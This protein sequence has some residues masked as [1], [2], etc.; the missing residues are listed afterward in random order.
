MEDEDGALLEGEPPEGSL[1]LVAVV[2]GQNRRS[3]GMPVDMQDPNI[4]RPATA[5]PGLGVALVGQ[6]P[7]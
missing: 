3:L 7:M 4:G 2:D 1:E 5:T 6:D